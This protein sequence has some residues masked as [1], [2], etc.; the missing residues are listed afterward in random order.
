MKALVEETRRAW[1]ALGKVTYGPMEAEK[2][3]LIFRRSLYITQ[4]LQAGDVLTREN[5]CSL[6]P[7]HGLPPKF[8]QRGRTQV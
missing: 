7:G 4:D 6:R 3:S 5:I 2:N 8:M 1:Q